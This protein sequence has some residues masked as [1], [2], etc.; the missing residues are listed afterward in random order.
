MKDRFFLDSNIIIYA[1]D[2]RYP[3]KLAIANKL[4]E[5]GFAAETGRVSQQVLHEFYVTVTA[6][7]KPGLGHNAAQKITTAFVAWRPL[8]LDYH[9]TARAFDIEASYRFS[10][11]DSLIVA[12]ALQQDCERLYSEDMQHGMVIEGLTIINPFL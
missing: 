5:N 7:L 2:S 6:K 4:I 8:P 3:D 12:A 11:W 1:K 10:F 9:L